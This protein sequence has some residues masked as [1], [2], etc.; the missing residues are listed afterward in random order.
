MKV[1]TIVGA[2]P[3]FI[4]AAPL[5]KALKNGG[6]QEFLLHTGQHYDH[7]MS[8]VFFEELGL[9]DANINLNVRS[10]PHGQ[11]TGKMLEG[12]EEVLLRERPDRVIVFGDTNSTLAGAIAAIKLNIPLAHIEAGMRSFNRTMPEEHN[13]VLTDHCSDFLFCPTQTAVEHLKNEGITHGVFLVG[14]PMFDAVQLFAKIAHQRSTI[15]NTLGLQKSGYLLATIHRAYNT[16]NPASLNKILTV[17]K[18]INEPVVLPM[19]PRTRQKMDE[20]GLTIASSKQNNLKLIEPVSY[21]DML[22]LEQN[23]R[24]ILTDSGGVQKEAYYFAIPCV[25]LRS[26]TEWVE[27]LEDGWNVVADLD[28]EIILN[29]IKNWTQPASSPPLVFGDGRSSQK[30][31]K[32]LEE[33]ISINRG[34]LKTSGSPDRKGINIG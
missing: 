10:G 1:V 16:D 9:P 6:H 11:Q 23:S 30:I 24:M 17:L 20:F 14:D 32:I 15:L 25:T 31:V 29:R 27:T 34:T 7:G 2:R 13:R 3:Q 5:S 22:E 28:T 26:E 12:I 18:D 21:L 8:Q 19:H 4:K 33:S